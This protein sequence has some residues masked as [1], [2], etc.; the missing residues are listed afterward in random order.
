LTQEINVFNP[1]DILTR[2]SCPVARN[3]LIECV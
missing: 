3:D 1:R 2:A